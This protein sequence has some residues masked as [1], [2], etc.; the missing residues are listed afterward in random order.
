M[1][2]HSETQHLST[3]YFSIVSFCSPLKLPRQGE[4]VFAGR[5]IVWIGDWQ[6]KTTN[7][8]RHR[9]LTCNREQL[10]WND[11]R[12]GSA[13]GRLARN[14]GL[15]VDWRQKWIGT[16]EKLWTEV[17][18]TPKQLPLM[19]TYC[20]AF[21]VVVT[22]GRLQHWQTYSNQMVS[23]PPDGATFG[24]QIEI[25]LI[26]QLKLYLCMNLRNSA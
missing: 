26:L 1:P 6:Q 15:K 2:V 3:T 10:S 17:G 14:F 18:H 16:E 24:H 7:M 8:S 25:A 4:A 20:Q 5:R 11:D 12:S 9:M 22:W 13:E 21:C 23:F 19:G